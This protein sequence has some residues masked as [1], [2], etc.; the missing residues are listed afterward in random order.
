MK[1]LLSIVAAMMCVFM[2]FGLTACESKST[3]AGKSMG[4]IESIGTEIRS[5]YRYK[6]SRIELI[7]ADSTADKV[8]ETS[9]K[10]E[11]VYYYSFYELF[12]V[13][14]DFETTDSSY[15]N[16][17]DIANY[18]SGV[19]LKYDEEKYRTKDYSEKYSTY[20]KMRVVLDGY[21]KVYRP[22]CFVNGDVLTASYY[23]VYV[24]EEG[25]VSYSSRYSS[26]FRL[27]CKE[28]SYEDYKK[29][30][31][32]YNKKIFNAENNSER[33]KLE[34]ERTEKYPDYTVIL[35]QNKV[36]TSWFDLDDEIIYAK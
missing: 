7:D 21:D 31:I 9:N 4:E 10:N 26:G 14:Q 5:I 25:E 23:S 17:S 32:E 22:E 3:S 33:E 6:V 12:D 18:F 15:K 1:K 16:T 27:A 8:L 34:A 2:L 30:T 36:S 13:Y 19:I 35:E 29:D 11:I 28:V 24:I 20:V